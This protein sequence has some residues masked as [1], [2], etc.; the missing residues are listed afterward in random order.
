MSRKEVLL[1]FSNSPNHQQ[2]PPTS[3]TTFQSSNLFLPP[4][5]LTKLCTTWVQVLKTSRTRNS[6]IGGL[7]TSICIRICIVWPLT[8]TLCQVSNCIIFFYFQLLNSWVA[9]SVSVEQV[10]SQGHLVLPYIYNRLLSQS[11]CALLCLGDWS[12]QGFVHNDDITSAAV[13]PDV[14]GKKPELK[15]GWDRINF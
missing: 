4:V 3:L 14:D 1:T 8:I 7:S 15:E 6:F 10:F 11:T 9:T 2:S 5:L 13:L 12:L